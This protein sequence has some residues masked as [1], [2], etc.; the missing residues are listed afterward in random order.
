M[1][2]HGRPSRPDLAA[3][4]P[5][6]QAESLHNVVSCSDWRALCELIAG[7]LAA[8]TLEHRRKRT[9]AIALAMIGRESRSRNDSS[10]RLRC[11]DGRHV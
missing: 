10:F 6:D 7:V 1:T 3:H 4:L 8:F 5:L 2:P 11:F 9:P